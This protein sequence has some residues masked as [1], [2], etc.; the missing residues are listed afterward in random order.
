M[1]Y[2]TPG[3]PVPHYLPELTQTHVHESL[4]SSSHLILCRSLLF[5]PSI[6]PSIR[7]FSSESALHIR[8]PEYW[9]FSFSIRPSSEYS[10]LI[11]F[12]IG[13]LLQN[14]WC[15]PDTSLPAAGLQLNF[16]ASWGDLHYL[17]L[18]GLEVVGQ[19]G[20]ALSINPHQ[21]SASPRDLNDLPEYTDD[22]RTL[23][24]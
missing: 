13:Y 20:Q 2:S 24:K 21:I 14:L 19:D 6:F 8:W 18:T 12:R 1:D 23:D 5:P 7:V 11:S 16:T 22:S 4:M 17:G 9:S 3:F 10:E 15:S